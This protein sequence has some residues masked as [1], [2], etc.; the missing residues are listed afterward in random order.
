MGEINNAANDSPGL[1]HR[2]PYFCRSGNM[3]FKQFF[4]AM[5][6]FL[7]GFRLGLVLFGFMFFGQ[8]AAQEAP[9]PPK[10][11]TAASPTAR[12]APVSDEPLLFTFALTPEKS[13]GDVDTLP[14]PGFRMYNPAR[15]PLID[16]GTLGNLG[17]SARPLLY[18]VAPQQGFDF[19][20]HAFDLYTLKSR[21]LRF[22]RNTRSFSEAFFSQGRN[23]LEAM[24]NARFARTFSDGANFSLDYRSINNLGQFNYQRD[25]HNA[26]SAGLW[27]PKGKRYDVFLIFTKNVFRQQE[28]GGIVSDTVF[29][30]DQFQGPLAAD[31]NL[32]EGRAITR[33]DDQT[34]HLTQHFRFAGATVGKRALRATHTFEWGKLR[35][36]FSDGDT[37]TGLELDSTFY[38]QFLVDTRG[39]RN[40]AVLHRYDNSFSINTFKA[41]K[42]GSPS[43]LLAIGLAHSFFKLNQEPSSYTFSNLFFTGNLKFSPSDRFQFSANAA[44]GL[45]TNIGEYQLQGSIALGLGKAGQLRASLLSQRRPPSMFQERLFVSKREIWNNDFEKPVENTLAATYALPLIGFEATARTT[46]I[47]NFLYFDQ[48]GSPQ[49]TGSPLQVL[50]LVLVENLKLGW[51]HLDNTVALQQANRSDVLRLPEWFSKNS[52]YVSGKVFKKRLLLAT[53]FDFRMNS[54]FQPD[55]Y[56]PMLGQ[57]HLQDSIRQKPYPWVD[58][59]LAFKVQSFRFSIRYEN[60]YTWIDK[61]KVFYQTASYPQPFGALRFGIS[62]RFM[63]NNQKGP[64]DDSGTGS[65]GNPSNPGI[66]FGG[67]GF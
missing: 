66:N 33:Y 35:Y 25:R 13:E 37:L 34:L 20:I 47:N 41:K 9:G 27:V 63:D 12:K 51:L 7:Q 24:L 58:V 31:I 38:G 22:Y 30:G 65:G 23:N 57:F 43:D 11:P 60:C 52:L 55:G 54:A 44:L 40:F 32:P 45:L 10:A 61:T 42:P 29:L 50:Q 2:S 1:R 62:W 15:R 67:R 16:Y 18:E 39:I 5:V 46:L 19:G 56:H 28:N 36:K 48:N 17:S 8:L 6:C 59:F 64:G 49:Q 14:D 21:D 53:G 4:Q 26:L 3:T